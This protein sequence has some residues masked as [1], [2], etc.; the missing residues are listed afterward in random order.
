MKG[1]KEDKDE[2]IKGNVIRPFGAERIPECEDSVVLK[3]CVSESKEKRRKTHI[4]RE[5]CER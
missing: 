5:N 4:T 2:E 3:N 1:R